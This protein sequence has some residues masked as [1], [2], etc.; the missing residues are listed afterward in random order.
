MP[1]CHL[2]DKIS[3]RSSNNS[4]PLD[5]QETVYLKE[6]SSRSSRGKK[7]KK[8]LKDSNAP[9]A[10]LTGYVRFLNE[11][12]EKVRQEKPEL[13]FYEITKILGTMWSQMPQEQKQSY[14]NEAEKDKERYSKE[15]VE[16]QQTDAY[17]SFV[18]KQ[19]KAERER[20]NSGNQKSTE[21]LHK[22]DT[23]GRDKSNETAKQ[24]GRQTD[25]KQQNKFN[26]LIGETSFN[27]PIF[28]EEFLN[29]NRSREAELRKLGDLRKANNDYEEQNA[30][31]SKHIDNM[32]AA[33]DKLEE[34]VTKSREENK[35]LHC[36]LTNFRQMLSRSLAEVRLPQSDREPSE[37]Y[38]EEFVEELSKMF[39]N[40]SLHEEILAKV[41]DVLMGVS[42]PE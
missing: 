7:R 12:R 24:A 38:V 19:E 34:E 25:L 1:D 28:S 35:T 23:N 15:L 9:K 8:S 3:L 22:T 36:H 13:P 27:I 31:L 32:K 5:K 26:A 33:I 29:Y 21:S 41:K 4:P 42:I 18:A 30:M 10:P 37:D 6:P 2:P 40:P 11:H 14:L 17:K 16:Y 20:E 39:E